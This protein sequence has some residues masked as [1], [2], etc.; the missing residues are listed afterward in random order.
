MYKKKE[1]INSYKSNEK[2]SQNFL[3]NMK[4]VKQVKKNNEKEEEK[5]EKREK[6]K[7][8]QIKN[9]KESCQ[10]LNKKSQKKQTIA[11]N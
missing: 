9:A 8:E 2:V 3:K 10:L 1:V 11:K 7:D 5:K 6:R 4:K